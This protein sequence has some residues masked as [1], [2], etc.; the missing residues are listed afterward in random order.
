MRE[1]NEALDARVYARAAAG[2]VGMDRYNELHWA[3]LERRARIEPTAAPVPAPPPVQAPV[4]PPRPPVAPP[5]IRRGI[6]Y[7]FDI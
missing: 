4:S 2:R 3:E 6:R 7:R 5:P 1:R